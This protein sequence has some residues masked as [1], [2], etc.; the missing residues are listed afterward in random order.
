M[1]KTPGQIAC[2]SFYSDTPSFLTH[3]PSYHE[4][5]EDTRL[6]W[7][8]AANLILE[9]AAKVADKHCEDVWGDPAQQSAAEQIAAGIRSLKTTVGQT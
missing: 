7:E 8:E 3:P 4:M 1:K 6:T 2:E 5:T 9:E